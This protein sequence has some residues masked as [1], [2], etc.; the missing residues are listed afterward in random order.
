MFPTVGMHHKMC[1]RL[2]DVQKRINDHSEVQFVQFHGCNRR[3]G[4]TLTG[5]DC[6]HHD[7][8]VVGNSHLVKM[9]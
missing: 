8:G 7:G 5:M 6:G 9:Y 1:P 4:L 2:I 3:G